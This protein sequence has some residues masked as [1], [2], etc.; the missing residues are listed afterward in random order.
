MIS[1]IVSIYNVKPFLPT[2][3][4]S[5]THQ[6]TNVDYEVILVDD[7]STD[8]SAALCDNYAKKK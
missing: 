4:K 8:G 1:I 3:I 7:G 5:L 6:D 2:T